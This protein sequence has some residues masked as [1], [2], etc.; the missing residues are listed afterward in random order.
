[1]MSSMSSSYNLGLSSAYLEEVSIYTARLVIPVTAPIIVNGSVAVSGKRVLHVGTRSWV[2]HELK[3]ELA[4][5]ARVKEYYWDGILM[6]GLVNA[7]THLQYT[8]MAAV[9]RGSYPDFHSWELAFNDVYNDHTRPQAW[10]HWAMLGARQMVESGTTAAADIVTDLDAAIALSSQGMHGIAYWEV[11]GWKN[12]DWN[13][14]GRFQLN[15]ELSRMR[16]EQVTS[17]GISPHAPY[18]L[19]SEPFVDLPGMARRLN[20]RLHIHLAETPLEASTNPPVLSTY[21]SPDWQNRYWASYKELKSQGKHASAVQFVDQLGSLGPDVHIAHGVWA[22]EEDRRIL[23]QR[24]VYV[25]LCPR[26]NRITNTGKD[27]PVREYL[28]EGNALSIGTDSLSSSPSL[29]L[30]DECAALYD[31]ARS[32]GYGK[33]DLSHRLIHM[34]TL[35]GAAAM[36][37]HVG[38]NRIGQINA[39]ALADLA[40]L[41]IPVRA[42]T[43]QEL[44]ETLETL[45]RNGGGKNRATLI[46]GSLV[47]GQET[48]TGSA[49]EHLS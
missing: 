18:T 42:K 39:G 27:A 34:L 9:G 2:Q 3:S 23:R 33:A 49:P 4:P 28:E 48:L 7:H 13:E 35:G 32:Q 14:K 12:K 20:M 16:R 31:L 29:D 17:I 30:L 26:S 40:F 19:D 46:A 15:L 6:P 11:M 36:G 44:E 22:D 41:D 43:P 8:G 24:Q 1:M 25:A 5:G 45:V 21:S 10:R 47:Y 38:A 37:M